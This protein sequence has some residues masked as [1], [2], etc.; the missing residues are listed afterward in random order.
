MTGLNPYEL[1]AGRE[2]DAAV[3]Q[4]IFGLPYD[5][6][7]PGYSTEAIEADKLRKWIEATYSI[8]VFTGRTHIPG[9][10]W[11]ARYEMD[12]GNPTEVI[13]E[14]YALAICRLAFL[15]VRRQ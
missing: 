15:R 4:E 11:F 3:H 10:T 14:T 2:L 9:K 7:C 6:A 1:M 13:A 5:D 8:S 12:L